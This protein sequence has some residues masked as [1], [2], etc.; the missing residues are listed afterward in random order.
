MRTLL[1]VAS[2][3]AAPLA[4]CATGKSEVPDC[5]KRYTGDDCG[6]VATG[7]GTGTAIAAA[8]KTA[9]GATKGVGTGVVQGVS[10]FCNPVA[11]VL[12][13]PFGIVGGAFAGIVDGIGH[14][15]SE[16]SCHY[17]FG[18][19]LQYAWTRDYRVGTQNAQVP[20]H[21]YRAADGSDGAWNEGAYWPGGPK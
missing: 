21:R 8:N 7:L 6:C 9:A 1:A 3:A 15:P 13:A 10:S 4:G 20:E 14:V 19:S 12:Y 18:N 2:L 17:Y 11:N 5:V 16:Q